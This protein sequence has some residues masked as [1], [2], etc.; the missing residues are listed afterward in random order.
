MT[1]SARS[2]TWR[3]VLADSSRAAATSRQTAA[4]RARA[5]WAFVRASGKRW[6]DGELR[7]KRRGA[8]ARR[9]DLRARASC[10]RRTAGR[11][12]T[13]ALAVRW[14]EEMRKFFETAGEVGAMR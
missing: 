10:S 5:A 11:F 8:T 4:E 7:L 3:V 1:D 6:F 14:A 13:R 2:R 12:V 9:R